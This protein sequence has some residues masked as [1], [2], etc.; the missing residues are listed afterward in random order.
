[1][2]RIEHVYAR[3]V[4][5]SRGKPTVEVE[6]TCAGRHV[7]R[8]IVPSG[9]ST[10]Q[11][12]ACE[13][14][15]G[16]ANHYDGAGVLLAVHNVTDE[17]A[18]AV[19]GLDAVDQK[20][21]D[22]RLCE[23]DGTPNKSRL[24]AN[25]I[26]G[27]S[28]ATAYAGASAVGIPLVEHLH[29]LWRRCRR[30][31][32]AKA[33]S[34][35]GPVTIGRTAGLGR[36]MLLPLPM[37]NM[38]SGGLHAGRNL[39]VQ[40]I[41][42]LPVGA[43]SYSQAL[44]WIVK[45]YRRLGRLLTDAGC[46]GYLIGDEG[47][48]G[49]KLTDNEQALQFVVRAIE[50]AR[51]RPGEDV[52]L[53]LDVASTHFFRDGKYHLTRNSP[54]PPQGE[55]GPG[56]EGRASLGS[57]NKQ[58]A[59]K[60]APHPRPLSP[61]GGEGSSLSAAEMV[62]LLEGWCDRYPLISIEDGVADDDWAGWKLLTETLGHRVQLIGDDL[63]VTNRERLQRG[64]DAGV[65]NSV[66]IKV[67]Q[68]GTLWETLETLAL[69]IDAGFWPVVSARSGETED[70][71]IADLVVATGAGQIK[72]G[73]VARSE[74]LAKYNQLLRLEDQLADRAGYLGGSIF[75]QANLKSQISTSQ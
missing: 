22:R 38:I 20:T 6:V 8:A 42:I 39:D 9:A 40:D 70:A 58:S 66:L 37:V 28:L 60:L 15:D 3:Q 44:E 64:V 2:T 68:I 29:T 30:S 19:L 72:I 56:A 21:L 24:G 10:G 31:Q 74:R 34:K 48:F 47:G 18:S 7:G 17:I 5:D 36:D 32:A 16:D 51:L 71:T 50:A 27:V 41:L 23:L 25:A 52:A 62:G 61:S 65:A 45:V 46:E 69:A 26:L 63:F 53:G 33:G 35:S 14:R 55:R 54:S 57:V 67:N 59:E 12:E 73:S 13:L 11:F 1:M 4:L 49:P 75:R 43:E